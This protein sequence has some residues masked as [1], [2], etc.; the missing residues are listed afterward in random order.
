MDV[1][2]GIFCVC[3]SFILV[4]C[5]LP[6][7]DNVSELRP[8]CG[9]NEDNTEAIF[10]LRYSEFHMVIP[11]L[12]GLCTCFALNTLSSKLLNKLSNLF[13]YIM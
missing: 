8:K 10:L 6:S 1:V 3:V 7:P 13:L 12:P 4:S 9:V 5:V 2:C 11:V